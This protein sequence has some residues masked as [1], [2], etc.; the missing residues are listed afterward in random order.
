MSNKLANINSSIKKNPGV[1]YT[2]PENYSVSE[3]ITEFSKMYSCCKF[4]KESYDCCR[5]IVSE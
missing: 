1:K 2:V 3:K 4:V 5:Q